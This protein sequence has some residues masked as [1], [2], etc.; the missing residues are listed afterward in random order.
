[1][2]AKRSKEKCT[3]SSASLISTNFEVMAQMS[4]NSTCEAEANASASCGW[5]K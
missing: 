4:K 2:I 1:M 5:R 3:I